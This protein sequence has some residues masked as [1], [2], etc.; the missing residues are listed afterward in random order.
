VKRLKNSGTTL[1]VLADHGLVDASEKDQVD[2]GKVKG[3]YECLATMP[4]GDARAVACFVR[5][6][7]VEQFLEIATGPLGSAC[8]CVPGEYLLEQGVFGPGT[9]H[10]ALLGRV[11]D[12]H[13]IAKGG[14]AFTSTLPGVD[15][16]FNIGNHG[17]M[18][19]TEM[20]VPLYIVNT[21]S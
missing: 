14:T 13:L 2:L 21:D 5:P 16:R 10:A 8:A 20:L 1:I 3:L 15:A 9:R 12:Y 6:G 18:S 17:G 11:G 19:A 7:K 4:S